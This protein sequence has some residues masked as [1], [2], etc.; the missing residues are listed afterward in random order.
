MDTD[1]PKTILIYARAGAIGDS[2]MKLPFIGAV[3]RTFPD[4]RITWLSGRHSY[5]AGVLKTDMEGLLDEVLTHTGIAVRNSDLLTTW[6]PLA[7]RTFDL[8]IDTQ[9]NP[10]RTMVLRRIRHRVFISSAADY[11]LSDRRPTRPWRRPAALID[12]LLE[13]VSLAAGKT[14]RPAPIPLSSPQ[15]LS[16]AE[17][18]LPAGPTYVGLA[19][20]AGNRSSPLVPMIRESP[21]TG[22]DPRHARR[23]VDRD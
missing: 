23:P 11:L 9:R 7:G 15:L 18:L 8:V 19:P 16:A 4:A 5:F 14:A 17:T 21:A 10:L 2:I 22:P 6:R 20:G 13:L 3:R 12:E 1:T